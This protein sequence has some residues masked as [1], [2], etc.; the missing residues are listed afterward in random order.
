MH[1]GQHERYGLGRPDVSPTGEADRMSCMIGMLYIW[2]YSDIYIYILYMC[3]YIYTHTYI[4]FF[5]YIYIF[6]YIVKY[7]HI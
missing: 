6:G 5:T 4:L 2:N 3:V 1:R 7:I